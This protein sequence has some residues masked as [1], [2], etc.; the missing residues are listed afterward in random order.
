[1]AYNKKQHLQDNIE[2]IRTVFN[3]DK[4][5]RKATP[6]EQAV[7][8]KYSGFGGLKC[9]LN[10]V[11]SLADAVHWTKSDLPLFSMVRELHSIIHENAE[12]RNE[13]RRYFNSLKNSV[14]TSFYTPPE[15]VRIMGQ[16]FNNMG[17]KPNRFLDPSAGMGEFISA[18]KE[19]EK[20]DE[21]VGIEK[22]LLTGKMLSY[23][24]PEKK[25]GT[26]CSS[27]LSIHD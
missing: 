20:I 13:Y 27:L 10:P 12:D 1:M 6:E 24:Y 16:V 8:R 11:K 25:I 15:V 26:G 23:L 14:L 2:A 7:L 19:L 17:I 5:K 22:D 4:E 3:L 9:I 21:V 18:F